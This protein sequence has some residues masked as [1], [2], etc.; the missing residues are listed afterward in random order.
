MLLQKQLGFFGGS[1]DLGPS[2]KT[3]VKDMG[4]FPF[5]KKKYSLWYQRARNG[6]LFVML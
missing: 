5:G 6:L 3:R 2:N 1:A 4:D